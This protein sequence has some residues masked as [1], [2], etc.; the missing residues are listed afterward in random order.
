M[1]MGTRAGK[2]GKSLLIVLGVILL[3]V[4]ALNFGY[5]KDQVRYLLNT[6]D[7]PSLPVTADVRYMEP[8]TIVIEKFNLTTPVIYVDEA[9]EEA[10]QDAMSRGVGH[11]PGTAK[12]GE[13]GNAYVFGHSSRA[14][15]N[16]SDYNTIFSLIPR[17]EIGDIVLA[18]DSEGRVYNYRV[19]RT[20]VVDP[21]DTT[22]LNQYDRK[23]RMLTLQTSWPLG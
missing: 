7:A 22:V 13:Y 1:G 9:T 15:W 20:F 16:N 21:N 3:G 10:F 11:Y 12:I 5:W 18:S 8:D 17:L 14:P 19:V 4:V 6:G 23:T 2:V